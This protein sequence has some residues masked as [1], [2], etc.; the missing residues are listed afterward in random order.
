M[1]SIMNKNKYDIFK[2]YNIES[3]IFRDRNGS[4][5]SASVSYKSGKKEIILIKKSYSYK[6]K[7]I[8]ALQNMYNTF[9]GN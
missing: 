2:E 3:I 5:V 8:S 1:C 7:L 4:F 6:N 9:K